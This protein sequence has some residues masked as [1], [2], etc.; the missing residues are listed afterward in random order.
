MIYEL[1]DGLVSL[2]FKGLEVI[3][4]RFVMHIYAEHFEMFDGTF[5][6]DHIG[7][8]FRICGFATDRVCLA[9]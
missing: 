2:G 5:D 1:V 4:G 9:K 8:H 3:D 7:R 6:F